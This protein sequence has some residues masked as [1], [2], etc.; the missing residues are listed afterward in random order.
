VGRDRE[1]R[2]RCVELVGD[3]VVEELANTVIH[4]WPPVRKRWVGSR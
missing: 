2:V 4:G 1:V 3:L